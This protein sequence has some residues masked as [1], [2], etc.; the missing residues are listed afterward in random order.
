M[1][2]RAGDHPDPNKMGQTVITTL[3]RNGTIGNDP[4]KS[5]VPGVNVAYYDDVTHHNVPKAM[6][7][8]LNLTGPVKRWRARQLTS[9]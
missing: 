2:T 5:S 8:F 7:D 1:P 6:W 3:A 9:R 4:G